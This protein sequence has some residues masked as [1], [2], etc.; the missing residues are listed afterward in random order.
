MHIC[1]YI[2]IYTYIYICIHIHMHMHQCPILS[3]YVLIYSI[4][5]RVQYAKNAFFRQ[6]W[7]RTNKSIIYS[8]DPLISYVNVTHG[9]VNFVQYSTCFYI[10]SVHKYVWPVFGSN[11]IVNF[12][13]QIFFLC[14]MARILTS[15]ASTDTHVC[16]C[17]CVCVCV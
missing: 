17:V 16:V 4:H 13:Y 12:M 6:L 2:C 9:V 8:L 14:I 3:D 7:V 1:I 15:L 11:C 10:I 5:S